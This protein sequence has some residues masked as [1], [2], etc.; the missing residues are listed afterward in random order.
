M[1]LQCH[2][3]MYVIID[4]FGGTKEIVGLGRRGPSRPS[5]TISLCHGLLM[6]LTKFH[7]EASVT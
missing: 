5:Y 6:I 1:Q 4:S 2:T 3:Y 7:P